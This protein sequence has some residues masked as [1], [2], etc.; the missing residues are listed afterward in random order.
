MN[1]D[2]KLQMNNE[3]L[4]ANHFAGGKLGEATKLQH[5]TCTRFGFMCALSSVALC[6]N[7]VS[8]TVILNT[9]HLDISASAMERHFTG[10]IVRLNTLWDFSQTHSRQNFK[11]KVHGNILFLCYNHHDKKNTPPISQYIIE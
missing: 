9:V 4:Q 1:T 10:C 5:S 3:L 7:P 11:L 8:R 2:I 6:E